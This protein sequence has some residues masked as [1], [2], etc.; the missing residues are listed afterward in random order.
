MNNKINIVIKSQGQPDGGEGHSAGQAVHGNVHGEEGLSA[1]V[2]DD[3]Q[4]PSEAILN[5]DESATQDEVLYSS[6]EEGRR[7]GARAR[8]VNEHTPG[9]PLSVTQVTGCLA[10]DGDRLPEVSRERSSCRRNETGV[11]DAHALSGIQRRVREASPQLRLER[12][13]VRMEAVNESGK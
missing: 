10:R 4:E 11:V 7:L 12:C 6:Y 5:R 9:E 8:K 1:N 2:R 3:A 13:R